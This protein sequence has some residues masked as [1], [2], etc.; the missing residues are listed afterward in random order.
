MSAEHAKAV[1][2]FAQAFAMDVS[3]KPEN[4]YEAAKAAA[5]A[6]DLERGMRWLAEDLKL[7]RERITATERALREDGLTDERRAILE[8]ERARDLRHIERASA[9]DPALANLRA[10]PAFAELF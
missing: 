8:G 1:R 2:H 9:E 5:Q 10:L 3:V 6:G 7:R 4:L